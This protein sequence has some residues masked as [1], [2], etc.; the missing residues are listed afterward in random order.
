MHV[1]SIIILK[2]VQKKKARDERE[3]R[4]FRRNAIFLPPTR[5]AIRIMDGI[6][7]RT[8]HLHFFTFLLALFRILLFHFHHDC[9]SI[10]KEEKGKRKRQTV[11]QRK[12]D[13]WF[14]LLLGA[15]Q[16]GQK[17]SS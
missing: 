10:L 6:F 5:V 14:F 12:S 7:E 17:W 13:V 2:Y 16:P 3:Y 9:K 11:V 4:H 15:R 8:T 1:L